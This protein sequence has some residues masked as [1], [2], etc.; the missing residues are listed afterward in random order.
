MIKA[1]QHYVFAQHH[2]SLDTPDV[3]PLIE[4]NIQIFSV[5]EIFVNFAIDLLRCR[6]LGKKSA[7]FFNIRS[8]MIN[9]RRSWLGD[10]G[11]QD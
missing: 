3:S 5:S 9:A 4:F 7:F 11:L 6:L 8:L 1:C 2:I 10:Y